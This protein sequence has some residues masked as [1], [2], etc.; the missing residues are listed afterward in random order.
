M[1]DFYSGELRT[2]Y[3]V[4]QREGKLMLR[5]PRGELELKPV[6][7]DVFSAGFP[8]G[9]ASFRRSAARASKPVAVT[10][11]RVRNLQFQRVK[12]PAAS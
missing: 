9:I 10:T 3:R 4:S 8:V 7:G 12:L 1:G 11:G 6:S 2:L 5:Y